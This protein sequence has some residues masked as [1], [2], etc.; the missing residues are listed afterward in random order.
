MTKSKSSISVVINTLNE[1]ANIQ[2]C[3]ESVS[4]LTDDSIVVDMHSDDRTIEIANKYKAKVFKHK[5]IGYVEPAR[6][7]GISKAKFDWI[8]VLDADE[9]LTSKLKHELIKI[10]NQNKYDAV[11]IPWSNYMLGHKMRA[12][13]WGALQD[14]HVRFFK[15]SK[16][17]FSS[18][19][20]SSIEPKKNAKIFYIKEEEKSVLHFPNFNIESFID[21]TNR[22]TTIEAEN[23]F[24][25]IK[26]PYS[27]FKPF[28]QFLLRYIKQKGYK[29]KWIGLFLSINIAYYYYLVNQKYKLMLNYKSK[30]IEL[31]TK[32]V[33]DRVSKELG[34]L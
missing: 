16:I 21:K 22:Y 33:R 27:K 26:K 7:L 32:K 14:T 4:N 17:N 19:I 2:Y 8:L 24:D 30:N 9:I 34:N 6:Q 28:K 29:D 10:Y 12:T 15:K 3:L 5:K 31:E 23:I 13:G 1:E 11:S 18:E 25:G 20:H